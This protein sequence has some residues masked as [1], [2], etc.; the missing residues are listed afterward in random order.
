VRAIAPPL[1]WLLVTISSS[2][3]LAVFSTQLGLILLAFQVL[4]GILL[5]IIQRTAIRVPE[6][7][8]I[9]QQAGLSAALVDAIQ[10]MEEIKV[11]DSG[12]F[13]DLQV[14]RFNRAIARLQLK[15]V[16]ISSSAGAL[17]ACLAQLAAWSVLLL[18]IPLVSNAQVPG[19]FLAALVLGS[20]AS[21]EAAQAL[22]LA[23][24]S[25]VRGL[26][27]AN[28]LGEIVSLEPEVVDPDHPRPVSA[29]HHLE[30][31]DLSF[32]YPLR[33][34][35][36]ESRPV[37]KEI[38][39]EL[40]PGKRLAIVGPSGVGKSTLV[41]LLLRFWDY[42]EG[43]IL[44]DQEDLR[45]YRQEDIRRQFS[46]VSQPVTLFNGT[47]SDN[48]RLAKP[49][50][51]DAELYNVLDQAHLQELL[52]S[53]PDGLQTWIGEGGARLSAGE[54]QRLAVARAL[55]KEAPILVLDEPTAHLDLLTERLLVQAILQSTQDRALL[56]I[57]HRLAGMPA[58]D[59]I[60]VLA[61][62]QITER[63]QH[64][65]LIDRRGYYRRMWD[66]QHQV[67]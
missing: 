52:A 46:I 30:C 45:R 53:L 48:L 39:F 38:S 20:T 56:W 31:A 66:L 23:T 36:A 3:L 35:I 33:D 50:A 62:G 34:N 43:Q 44:L 55:L 58:M 10:G 29:A 12:K 21:F 61:D 42:H 41:N 60:L 57:T 6:S 67:L 25:L 22:P 59:E 64:Q 13:H 11:F 4:A 17:A 24:Q 18:A 5:P 1:V 47:I 27:A 19:V 28:S 26:T 49:E 16:L 9:K 51:A 40:P 32:A 7:E 63:G 54:K 2:L 37:L 8:L 65:D 15:L 14:Q